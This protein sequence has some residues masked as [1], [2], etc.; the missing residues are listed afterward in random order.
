M[1]QKG[2]AAWDLS[3]SLL[4]NP[5]MLSFS[6]V[7]AKQG[8]GEVSSA[9][10]DS[11]PILVQALLQHMLPHGLSLCLHGSCHKGSFVPCPFLCSV[12]HT[13]APHQHCPAAA[14]PVPPSPPGHDRIC[15]SNH[16]FGD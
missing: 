13:P 11:V 5:I 2:S 3:Q 9:R 6:S 4:I 1:V 14:A 12:P 10:A 16:S 7:S 15:C 8:P